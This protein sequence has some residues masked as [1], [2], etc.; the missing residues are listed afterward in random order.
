[1]I[2]R[3]DDEQAARLAPLFTRRATE[4]VRIAALL[5]AYGTGHAFFSTYL[6]NEGHAVL[7]QIDDTFL[8]MDCGADYAEL[9]CF[10]QWNPYFL[11]LMGAYRPLETIA[12]LLPNGTLHRHVQMT[13]YAAMPS[14]TPAI[15]ID[16]HPA[17][18]DIYAVE[19]TTS[20]AFDVWYAD[21]SHRIRHCCARA[22]LVRMDGEP[23]AACLISAESR[24]AGLI[25]SVA[26]K[27]Q[28]RGRGLATA[29]VNAAC[30]DLIGCGKLA[31]L[32]CEFSLC[33]FYSQ[34]GF[35]R[36]FEIGTY[37]RAAAVKG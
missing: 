2:A 33:Q 17:L 36:D 9:A 10:M 26:T 32:E 5:D 23:V 25:S 19:G 21:I 4:S 30:A 35:L 37:E 31:V 20:T 24:W 28:W 22:Y 15:Q 11:R 1:M 13:A 7:A 8:L 3:I 18:R 16:R 6:Q 12:A 29:L 34:L 27:E 14:K